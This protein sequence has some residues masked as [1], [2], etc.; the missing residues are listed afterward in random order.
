MYNKEILLNLSNNS[1][2]DFQKK[3]IPTIDEDTILGIYTNDLKDYAK[4]LFKDNDYQS[5]LSNL[6]HQY[7]E[8]NQLH[9]FIINLIK[10]YDECLNYLNLFLPYIDNWAT[11]DQL[12]PNVL[13]KDLKLLLL[14]IKQWL[15]SEHIYTIR[16]GIK[17]L[18]NFYLDK[19]FD[20]SII[21]LVLNVNSDDYYVKMMMAWFLQASLVK[22]YDIVVTYFK[23]GLIDP[24]VNNKAISKARESRQISI[25]KK[26]ELLKFK[27]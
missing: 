26:R 7:F 27:K 11:C 1:L 9:A 4:S 19:A 25:D 23:D 16:F 3:L 20:K 2:K 12:K 18:M 13:K 15:T 6:P 8:E 22:Q 24:W 21:D 5:F 14:Q 17:C 10:D